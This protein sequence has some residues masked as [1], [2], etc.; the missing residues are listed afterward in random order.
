MVCPAARNGAR[1][2]RGSG[3]WIGF[4]GGLVAEICQRR[5]LSGLNG[6]TGP[7]L[8]FVFLLLAAGRAFG[9]GVTLA[10]DAVSD[11]SVVGYRVYTGPSA[12]DYT[13]SIA[14][15]NTTTYTESN[16]VEGATYHFAATAYDAAGT[17]S[18]FSNDVGVTIPYSAPVAQ[19]SAS[20]T[21]GTAPL[22]LN[23]LN[24]STGT[25]STYAWVFGDGTTSSSQ[26]PS[27]VYSSAGVY[28]V[29]LT[30]TGPG[31]TNTKTNSNYITVSPPTKVTTTTTASSSLNPSGL[32]AAVT[33][34]ATVTGSAP[35]GSVG[36]AADGS[37]LT[38]CGAVAVPAGGASTKTA[39]CS[40]ASLA[41]G[42][43][44]ITAAYSGDASNTGSVSVSLSQ[45]VKAASS[46]TLT[47]RLAADG[48]AELA[49]FTASV[50]GVNPTGSVN[51][52]DSGISIT[53]CGA[54]AL[55]GSGSTR[56]AVC[57]TWSLSEG[58]HSIVA[59]YGGD[60]SNTASTSN[61]LAADIHAGATSSIDVALASNGGVASA[62]SSYPSF[63]VSAVIDGD[64][65][66][67]NW[68]RGGGWNSG[69]AN[70][71]PDW[72]QVNFSGQKTIDQ[73]VVYT[74]QDNYTNPVDP[75]DNLTFA[76]FGV[77][78]FQVQGWSGT[79]W[80]DLG[81]VSGSNLVKRPV[82]FPAYT[83]NS[84]RVNITAALA[85]FARIT[86]IEAW[87]APGAAAATTTALASSA[88]PSAAGRSVTLTASVNG[89]NPTGSVY[90][91]DGGSDIA[92]CGGVALSGSGNTRTAACS[93]AS[94]AAGTH[95]IVANYAGDANNLSSASTALAQVVKGSGGSKH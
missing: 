66:G 53:G 95:S 44:S 33:F 79:A 67:L 32:G 45:V 74:L 57:R 41:I 94:L 58:T 11:P 70:S 10:W 35:T 76:R 24:T 21:S 7:G 23:F 65:T 34:T 31:G 81:A 19:F 83:T 55:T 73:V 12:G 4:D 51:F 1:A 22:A 87:T 54:V 60:A 36:F 49:K 2:S 85:G 50:T 61:A 17:Q 40:T 75:P 56:T 88:N 59:H 18:G 29:S 26:N 48:L 89:V 91:T 13:S 78:A 69:T 37:T 20:A 46:T 39:T 90:F 77:T 27:H 15:G 64:R 43:H 3:E 62:S 71:F 14:V 38:G 28:T 5:T 93:T 80:V 68:G 30:V 25:I 84:I 8:L 63:P 47:M 82:S 16:L 72:V 9:G 92:G 52:T 42:T 6:L 86:E